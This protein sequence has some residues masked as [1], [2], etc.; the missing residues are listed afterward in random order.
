MLFK[1]KKKKVR[2]LI[3]F[4]K[5]KKKRIYSFYVYSLSNG[6]FQLIQLVKFIVLNFK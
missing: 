4:Y 1:K 2:C 6:E 5:Q 3:I